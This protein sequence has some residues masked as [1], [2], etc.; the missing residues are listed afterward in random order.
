ML[1]RSFC[2]LAL[3]GIDIMLEAVNGQSIL[4]ERLRTS[5]LPVEDE[6][7]IIM[8]LFRRSYPV[9]QSIFIN[10]EKIRTESLIR[11]RGALNK[12]KLGLD[13]QSSSQ[14][15]PIG[16]A[17]DSAEKL[18]ND[19]LQMEHIDYLIEKWDHSKENL[20]KLA[21]G[22]SQ[23]TIPH[24]EITQSAQKYIRE[25]GLRVEHS[26]KAIQHLRKD[27]SLVHSVATDEWNHAILLDVFRLIH[28]FSRIF[29]K[30]SLKSGSEICLGPLRKLQDDLQAMESLWA[31]LREK[32]KDYIDDAQLEGSGRIPAKSIRE[33]YVF[34][35]VSQRGFQG[36]LMHVAV[37]DMQGK[38]NEIR[39]IFKH[40][41]QL[42]GIDNIYKKPS[43]IPFTLPSVRRMKKEN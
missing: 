31:K 14:P 36:R 19:M 10:L 1:N 37:S 33:L 17:K 38:A 18:V 40:P 43:S 29:P 42:A 20:E 39:K 26:I 22:T 23:N 15:K 30:L 32:H 16:E 21:T 11:I 2:V 9:H 6:T 24:K 27:I 35:E 12:I 4:L 34:N 25:H 3:P 8:A 7:N 28:F 5:A 13:E 41:M